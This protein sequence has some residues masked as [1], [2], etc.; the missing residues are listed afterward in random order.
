MQLVFI[1]ALLSG[2]EGLLTMLGWG[3]GAALGAIM[4]V[5][6]IGAG[7]TPGGGA[8]GGVGDDRWRNLAFEKLAEFMANYELR[9]P[10]FKNRFPKGSILIWSG[11]VPARLEEI[12]ALPDADYWLYRA[13]QLLAEDR[14][15]E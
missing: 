14:E 13:A 9:S 8:P 6:V 1:G 15:E 4:S 10:S 3:I 2:I 7:S 11:F 12:E 5:A